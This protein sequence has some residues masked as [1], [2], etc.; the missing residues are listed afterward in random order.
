MKKTFFSFSWPW[1]RG[2][3]PPKAISL[4]FTQSWSTSPSIPCP[5]DVGW[6]SR[7]RGS[8]RGG[9]LASQERFNGGLL[10]PPETCRRMHHA[11]FLR[12]LFPTTPVAFIRRVVEILTALLK[13]EGFLGFGPKCRC[14]PKTN[15]E[16][17]DRERCDKVS[18][19]PRLRLCASLPR[20]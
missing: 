10:A 17:R 1:L 20:K 5:W 2:L 12:E 15:D 4:L 19:L 7:W 8:R 16:S 3:M 6:T 13:S 11:N 9:L 14:R 18:Q